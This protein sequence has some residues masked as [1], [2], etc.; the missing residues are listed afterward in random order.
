MD[1][2]E[3]LS[4]MMTSLSSLLTQQVQLVHSFRSLSNK[5]RSTLVPIVTKI[6][7]RWRQ[8]E[9]CILCAK[10]RQN[11]KSSALCSMNVNIVSRIFS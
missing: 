7:A 8:M 4:S 1:F 2:P 11:E 3:Q 9:F 5:E 6:T 10:S